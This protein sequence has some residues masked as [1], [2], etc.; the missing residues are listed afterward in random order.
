MQINL[1]VSQVT[2]TYCSP[3]P[4]SC[5]FGETRTVLGAS[6]CFRHIFHILWVTP[7]EIPE[8]QFHWLPPTIHFISLLPHRLTIV[9]TNII[10]SHSLQ[11]RFHISFHSISPVVVLSFSFPSVYRII[12]VPNKPFISTIYMNLNSTQLSIALHSINEWVE[13]CSF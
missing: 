5:T 8:F 1:P 7:K 6:F 12:C 13:L 9:C 2:Y 4:N 3:N 11:V 10:S